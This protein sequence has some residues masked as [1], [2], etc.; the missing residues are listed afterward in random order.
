MLIP[1][2]PGEPLSRQIYAFVRAQILS[3]RLPS[4]SKLPSTRAWARQLN[5]SR[6]TV[7]R[8]YED[9][10]AEGYIQGARGS[11][12]TVAQNLPEDLGRPLSRSGTASANQT[13][14]IL[15]DYARRLLEGTRSQ[16]LNPPITKDPGRYDFHYGNRL[17][18]DFPYRAWQRLSA[19][20]SRVVPSGAPDSG[21]AGLRDALA[22]HLSRLRAVRCNP[23]QIVIVNGS[24]QALDLVTRL[25]VNPGDQVVIEEP[26]YHGA[27]L[28]FQAAGARLVPCPVDGEGLRIERLPA[29]PKRVPLV[30]VTPSHQFPTGT[31]LPLSR[32]LALIE[33]AT[34]HHSFIL[35]DDYDGELRYDNR[36]VEAVQALD[37]SGCVIYVGTV[38]KALSPEL[39]MGYAVLPPALLQAFLAAKWA[40]DLFAPTPS[41]VVLA[42]FFRDGHYD[43]HL[44]RLRECNSRRRSALLAATREFLGD[45]ASV[46]GVSAGL[47]AMIWLPTVPLSELPLLIDC[48]RQLG[49]TMYP[50]SNYYL[51]RPQQSGVL[52]G[53]SSLSEQEI[54]AGVE[55]FGEALR[56]RW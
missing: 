10:L 34:T 45:R 11:R 54:R 35:E 29:A 49:V 42:E 14:P 16:P 30:Y 52:A 7:L 47:H 55:L 5:V 17:A 18:V 31:V 13:A 1:L 6:T 12:T 19:R 22:A 36:P 15:S 33:W 48:A 38:S 2:R 3:G 50:V 32:R 8:A 21:H 24:Q 27:R 39:R 40:T 53:Y 26:H 25:L 56:S 4:G 9:L 41:Q 37:E 51:G 23:S 20:R 46:G 44:R 28:I 43:R